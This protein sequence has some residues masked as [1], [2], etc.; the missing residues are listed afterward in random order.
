ME[1][2]LGNILLRTV[3]FWSVNTKDCTLQTQR[4]LAILL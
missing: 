2:A 4:K 3:Q 1:P